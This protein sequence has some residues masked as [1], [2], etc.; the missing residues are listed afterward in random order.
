MKKTILFAMLSAVLFFTP[1]IALSSGWISQTGATDEPL[2]AVWGSSSQDVFA[3]GSDGAII[4]YNGSE[5]SEMDMAQNVNFQGIWGTSHENVYC[6]GDSGLIMQ[7]DG[8]EWKKTGSG[9]SENLNG[10]WIDSSSEVFIV[11]ERGTSLVCSDDTCLKIPGVSTSYSLNA[12]WGTSPE[13][14]FAVG[15]NGI[16]LHYDGRNW[17]EMDSKT[18]EI[19]MGVWGASEKDIFAVGLNGTI[20][21]YD[22]SKW[23]KMPVVKKDFYAVAGTSHQYVIAAGTDG[24]ILRYDGSSW[25][26]MQS[27]TISLIQ[28]LWVSPKNDSFGV[29]YNG[30]IMFNENMVPTALFTL[31]RTYGFVETVFHADASGCMDTEDDSDILK[32]RWD[33]ENDGVWDTEFST[34]KTAS[35]QYSDN[36][37]YTVVMEVMDTGTQTATSSQEITVSINRIPIALFTVEPSTGNTSTLFRFDA[38]ESFDGESD[39]DELKVR[40]DWENDGVWD[41][42]LSTDQQATHRFQTGGTYLVRLEVQDSGGLTDSTTEEVKVLSGLCVAAMLMGPDNPDLEVLRNFRDRVL[43]R[44][45]RGKTLVKY[46]YEHSSRLIEI[47][48]DNPRMEILTRKVLESMVPVV[49]KFLQEQ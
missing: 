30:L 3:A 17:S 6:V 33:W 29:G 25:T 36:A 5:W 40:W 37:T 24:K 9:T 39:A 12:V 38:S 14:V 1:V 26:E 31:D 46:Y 2:K 8:T 10:I 28:G 11:G 49:E 22:G 41:T 13:N 44:T 45:A 27:N 16:I 15:G 47:I 21:H 34:V 7:F 48:E 19:L 20:V 43:C 18:S 4:H 35:H 32:V 23:E 42:E